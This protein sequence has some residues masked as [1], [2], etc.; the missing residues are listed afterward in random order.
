[1]LSIPVYLYPNIFPVILDLDPTVRGVNRVMYQRDLTVQKGVK[2]KIQIQF[3]NSDQ[4]RIPVDG[5]SFLFTMFDAIENRQLLQKPINVLDDGTTLGLRGLAEIV[6]TEN[7]TIDLNVSSYTFSITY[8][9]PTD[10]TFL[11]A[12]SNTYYGINGTIHV[13]DDIY[14]V[15]QPSQEITSF[16]RRFD[17]DSLKYEHTSG[18]IYAYPEYNGNSALHTMAVYMTNFKG[19]VN[20]QGTLSNQ[21]DMAV[22][23]STIQSTTYNG[24]SGID[25]ANFNGVYSYVRIQFIPATN[26]VD[27]SNDDP[28]YY[29]SL[30]KV[31]YRS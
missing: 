25:Y 6:F 5:K 31:L 17:H 4:K 19:V 14:P 12:Y 15:L 27:Q 1:M 18:S 21:P 29:G 20:I 7:D 11:P 26:P 28:A 23:Y 10:G 16:I 2:N 9:D 30:D 8:Q 3:K 24:F 13:S 22:T